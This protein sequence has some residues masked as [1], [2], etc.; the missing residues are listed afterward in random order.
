MHFGFHQSFY[1]TLVAVQNG[2]IDEYGL[3]EVRFDSKDLK[4]VM[5][6]QILAL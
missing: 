5:F 2:L 4:A 6:H 3:A 1:L